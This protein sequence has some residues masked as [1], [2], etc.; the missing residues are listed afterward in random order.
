MLGD[1][2]NARN[3]PITLFSGYGFA[4]IGNV[5]T[6]TSLL[7]TP[8]ASHGSLTLVANQQIVGSVIHIHAHGSCVIS[9][10]AQTVTFQV[11]LNGG[12]CSSTAVA[13][14]PTTATTWEYDAF[15]YCKVVGAAS[16]ASMATSSLVKI[17]S[18][19]ALATI[20]PA[21]TT[22][23]TTV[24]TT[25]TQAIGFLAEEGTSETSN[26]ITCLFFSATLE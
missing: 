11:T 7:S 17:M 2:T 3:V 20:A 16:T 10:A 5:Q 19:L 14:V 23:S 9:T 22:L 1:G 4:G 12:L 6:P 18:P 13:S 15:I 26:Q 8:T 24:A 21:V 25:G